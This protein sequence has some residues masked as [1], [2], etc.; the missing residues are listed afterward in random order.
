MT[1]F[2]TI[3]VFGHPLMTPGTTGG[4]PVGGMANQL[5]YPKQSNSY[6]TSPVYYQYKPAAIIPEGVVSVQLAN[7][8]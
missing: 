2:A 1:A 6:D 7:D 3:S 8:C 5:W 4:I